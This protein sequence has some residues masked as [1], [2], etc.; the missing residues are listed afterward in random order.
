VRASLVLLKI[1]KI[2]E[3]RRGRVH[4]RASYTREILKQISNSNSNRVKV[5]EI[6]K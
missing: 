1:L 3:V 6:I 2:L 4:D 5:L